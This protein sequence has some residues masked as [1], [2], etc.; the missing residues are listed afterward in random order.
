MLSIMGSLPAKFGGLVV[1]LVVTTAGGSATLGRRTVGQVFAFW[2][3]LFGT[4][5]RREEGAGRVEFGLDEF[6]DAASQGAHRLLAQP[7]LRRR[8]EAERTV[9]EA[10]LSEAA[11][12]P[13]T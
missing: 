2:D 1:I 11:P 12:A 3:R 7:V 5:R 13:P 4:A 6:R 10:D 9:P 8:R